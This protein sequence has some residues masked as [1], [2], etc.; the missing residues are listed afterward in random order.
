MPRTKHPT[1]SIEP[2]PCVV[3]AL[4]TCTKLRQLAL[5]S[6]TNQVISIMPQNLIAL[7]NEMEE[8]IN[9]AMQRRP[10]EIAN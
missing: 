9:D 2:T 7:A 3:R 10:M 1:E 5:K 4:E 8:A 6:G